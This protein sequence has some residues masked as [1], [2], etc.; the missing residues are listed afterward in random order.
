MS[1]GIQSTEIS[2][3]K[4][5]TCVVPFIFRADPPVP[6]R[7]TWKSSVN[8]SIP[9]RQIMSTWQDSTALPSDAYSAVRD[10][11]SNDG[12]GP[13]GHLN[14]SIVYDSLDVDFDLWWNIIGYSVHTNNLDEVIAVKYNFDLY[15]TLN[16]PTGWNSPTY[17][18]GVC[19]RNVT[20]KNLANEDVEIWN[21][22]SVDL[23][24]TSLTTTLLFPSN[25][26]ITSN[27]PDRWMYFSDVFNLTTDWI[28]T[29]GVTD[30]TVR[31]GYATIVLG[32]QNNNSNTGPFTEYH[33]P[34]FDIQPMIYGSVA[35]PYGRY[36]S[37]NVTASEIVH[38]T[39][40][41]ITDPPEATIS[42][43]D[44]DALM[45]E[46]VTI[47]PT[48]AGLSSPVFSVNTGSS[49]P[50]GLTLN[51]STGVISGTPS[52]A[53]DADVTIKCVSG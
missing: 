44:T 52:E 32:C 25:S 13:Y 53:F 30:S 15:Y 20:C 11:G 3:I 48:V 2:L 41:D 24:E 26:E 4:A 36:T 7:L 27:Q 34:D 22:D 46:S 12:H 31:Y 8:T 45:G 33:R 29:T 1:I 37:S 38:N 39:G 40:G 35:F 51:P 9:T 28:P 14:S 10:W 19:I 17:P 16:I 6:P 47:T 43:S 21:Y 23:S 18:D 42:Y 49:L 5:A 50:A